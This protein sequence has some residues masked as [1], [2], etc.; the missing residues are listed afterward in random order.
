MRIAILLAA[1][2]ILAGPRER[3][4]Q[5]SD[6]RAYAKYAKANPDDLDP[7]MIEG[8]FTRL[9]DCLAWCTGWYPSVILG[10]LYI[11]FGAIVATVVLPLAIAGLVG[12]ITPEVGDDD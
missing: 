4:M 3:L 7:P 5:R 6:N 12:I 8:F 11:Q 10:V 9:F 1:D 2:A